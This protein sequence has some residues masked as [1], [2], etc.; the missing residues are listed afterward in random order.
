MKNEQ[1][2]RNQGSVFR[3]AYEYKGKHIQWKVGIWKP[4]ILEESR[5]ESGQKH[6]CALET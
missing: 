4:V 6:R 1:E 2:K 3:Q 5:G